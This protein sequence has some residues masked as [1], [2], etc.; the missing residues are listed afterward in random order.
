MARLVEVE[1]KRTR[2]GKLKPIK[3]TP[4]QVGVSRVTTGA[5]LTEKP[6]KPTPI[7]ARIG[8]VV[9]GAELGGVG[10]EISGAVEK[11]ASFSKAKLKRKK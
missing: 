9:T 2:Q 7:Q 3:P 4:M 5:R 10:G 11:K 6:I 8:R 1:T